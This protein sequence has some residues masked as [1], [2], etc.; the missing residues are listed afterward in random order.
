M[1]KT[2]PV[3][4]TVL[5]RGLSPWQVQRL[6]FCLRRSACSE[7]WVDDPA[8]KQA[9]FETYARACRVVGNCIGLTVWGVADQ[10]S[11]LGPNTDALL[12]DT[13]FQATPAVGVVHQLLDGVLTEP[14][15][16]PKQQP[17]PKPKPKQQPK[18]RRSGRRYV[19]HRGHHH[20]GNHHRGHRRH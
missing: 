6:R 9:V 1:T 8:A 17:K 2:K 5:S 11:W 18:P 4:S 20:G 13:S 19:R 3:H 15:Q 7:T 12:Y 14:K 10:Y 16:Q